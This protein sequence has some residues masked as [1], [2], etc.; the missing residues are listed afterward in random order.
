MDDDSPVFQAQVVHLL[1]KL[2]NLHDAVLAAEEEGSL[3]LG[4]VAEPVEKLGKAVIWNLGS[5]THPHWI[6]PQE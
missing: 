4:L 1:Q 2:C 5:I 3:Q 6:S